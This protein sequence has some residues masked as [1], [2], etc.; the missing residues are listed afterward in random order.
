MF[1]WV[2]GIHPQ[3]S[4]R[5]REREGG[6]RDEKETG[7]PALGHCDVAAGTGQQGC[8]VRTGHV[9]G[10]RSGSAGYLHMAITDTMS[11][12]SAMALDNTIGTQ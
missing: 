3:Y 4:T 1:C 9:L 10:G 8:M 12:A 11:E 6:G 7:R 2:G 5:E